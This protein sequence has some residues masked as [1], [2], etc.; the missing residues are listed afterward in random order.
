METRQTSEQY[1]GEPNEEGKEEDALIEG[2]EVG[3][4]EDE[5]RRHEQRVHRPVQYHHHEHAA[6]K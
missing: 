4:V 2:H 6:N 1:L 5:A 3:V